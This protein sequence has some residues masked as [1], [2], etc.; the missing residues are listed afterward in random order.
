MGR[1][2]IVNSE[3]ISRHN[4]GKDHN[5]VLGLDLAR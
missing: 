1:R 3:S 2:D 5:A 4:D